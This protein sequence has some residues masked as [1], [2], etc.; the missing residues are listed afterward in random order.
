MRVHQGFKH[1]A[2][3][4]CPPMFPLR[5]PTLKILPPRPQSR[6]SAASSQQAGTNQ[7]PSILHAVD[8]NSTV[9]KTIQDFPVEPRP[10]CSNCTILTGRQGCIFHSFA[11]VS[12]TVPKR[13]NL[14]PHPSTP[15]TYIQQRTILKN[16]QENQQDV[17]KDSRS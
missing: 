13:A 4:T 3:C 12:C 2:P 9:R 15:R 5:S 11:H 10:S 7:Q 17:Q 16:Q 1:H 6:A 14:Y 8:L